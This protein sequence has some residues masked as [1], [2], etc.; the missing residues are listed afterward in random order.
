MRIPKLLFLIASLPALIACAPMVKDGQPI[1]AKTEVVLRAGQ[2]IGQ[3]FTA[4]DRGLN[5][6]EVFLA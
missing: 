5:G 2:T 3:T 4:R 6:V 1:S